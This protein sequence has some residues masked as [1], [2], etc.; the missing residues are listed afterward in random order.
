MDPTKVAQILSSLPIVRFRFCYGFLG[1]GIVGSIDRNSIALVQ[2]KHSVY[3]NGDDGTSLVG[4]DLKVI[5][6]DIENSGDLQDI[7]SQLYVCQGCDETERWSNGT[8]AVNGTNNLTMLRFQ[9]PCF[10]PTS[11]T[12]ATVIPSGSTTPTTSASVSPS[13]NDH[14]HILAVKHCISNSYEFKYCYQHQHSIHNQFSPRPK[15]HSNSYHYWYWN[16]VP[17]TGRQI[18]RLSSNTV[19]RRSVKQTPRWCEQQTPR[20]IE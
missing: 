14:P 4:Y 5:A 12:T 9:I 2:V 20:K 16:S 7:K 18:E 6:K 13:R 10:T 15:R 3:N 11:T 8:W 1:G 17:A 19:S